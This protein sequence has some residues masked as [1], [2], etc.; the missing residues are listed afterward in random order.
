MC[1]AKVVW[2]EKKVSDFAKYENLCF[3][4][5]TSNVGSFALEENEGQGHVS[6][7]RPVV[8]KGDTAYIFGI[9]E[10]PGLTF[11]L[12]FTSLYDRDTI[13]A[14]AMQPGDMVRF[15][16]GDTRTSPMCFV[17]QFHNLTQKVF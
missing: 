4:S 12:S 9:K 8:S 13:E 11:Q 7:V 3:V 16:Y 10:K 5:Q 15:K 1:P 2:D 6:F 17:K 14:L